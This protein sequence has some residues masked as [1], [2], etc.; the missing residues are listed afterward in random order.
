MGED[1]EPAGC[2]QEDLFD[3]V[4]GQVRGKDIGSDAAGEAYL[5]RPH[6]SSGNGCLTGILRRRCLSVEPGRQR[7][8]QKYYGQEDRYATGHE[9]PD[10]FR[11][12]FYIPP[13]GAPVYRS[14]RRAGHA[15]QVGL[16]IPKDFTRKT[17]NCPYG[18]P[19]RLL[20]PGA[21]MLPVCRPP[22]LSPRNSGLIQIQVITYGLQGG[23]LLTLTPA[24]CSHCTWRR[25]RR[26]RAVESGEIEAHS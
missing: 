18:G 21:Q 20:F 24:P 12:L 8:C 14:S 25:L 2:S 23:T 1:I 5:Q 3:A 16:A 4:T 13:S 15:V 9:L 26:S 17:T 7:H 6:R 22:H 10:M 19:G 11:Y